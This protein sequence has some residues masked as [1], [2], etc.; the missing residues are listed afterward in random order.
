MTRRLV[1]L[2]VLAG[3]G[4]VGQAQQPPAP[5][6][7]APAPAPSTQTTSLGSDPNGNPLRKAKTGHVSNYDEA[8]VPPY[9]L[10][11]VLKMAD[12]TPVRDADAWRTKRRP[13]ILKAYETQIYGQLPANL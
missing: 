9:T 13:E 6:A 5:A 3:A 12:G 11:D 4:L 1:M 8:K 7:A 2:A 10:P